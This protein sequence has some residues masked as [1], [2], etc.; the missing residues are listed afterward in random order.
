MD[1]QQ[2][3][4]IVIL[5]SSVQGSPRSMHQ[6]YQDAMAIVR[7]FGK[8][9]IFIT[10]TCNPNWPEITS[11]L[12]LNQSAWE[13]PD[14]CSRVF[15]AKLK[16]LSEEIY[17]NHVLGRV[18]GRVHVIEFQKRGLPHAHILLILHDEDKP[19][20]TD[21]YDHLVSAE[22]PDIER[23]PLLHAIITSHNLHGPCGKIGEIEYPCPCIEPE[24][25]RKE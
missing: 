18:K 2:D 10:M 19:R 8:P 12:K 22:I 5:P 20:T 9:D 17:K 7:K 24:T 6:A 16:S 25:K 15:E 1:L 11:N 3:P 4:T 14:L 21:A 13:R 23:Q